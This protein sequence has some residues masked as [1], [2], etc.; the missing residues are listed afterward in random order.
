M[1]HEHQSLTNTTIEH[2]VSYVD[3]MDFPAPGENM[4]FPNGGNS[5]PIGSGGGNGGVQPSK[6]DATSSSEQY[7]AR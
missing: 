2:R 4:E 6:V 1:A 3:D 7:Q 5:D